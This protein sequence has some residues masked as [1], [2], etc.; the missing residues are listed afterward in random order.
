MYAA[1]A[2]NCYQEDGRIREVLALIEVLAYGKEASR[3]ELA[4]RDEFQTSPRSATS[5]VA[6]AESHPEFFRVREEIA[7][8]SKL[9]TKRLVSLV[10]RCVQSSTPVDGAT[11]EPLPVESVDELMEKAVSIHDRQRWVWTKPAFLALISAAASI[12]TAV[13]APTA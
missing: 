6:L 7:G 1:T 13:L 8:S 9:A 2:D 5:W 12:L 11:E 3:S 4:L 10:R